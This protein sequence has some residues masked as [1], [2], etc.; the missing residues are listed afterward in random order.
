MES[1][2]LCLSEEYVAAVQGMYEGNL[3]TAVFFY[4]YNG[5][6]Y[7]RLSLTVG[8]REHKVSRD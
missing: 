1:G 6:V 2:Q 3:C 5:F 7:M 8:I 4:C